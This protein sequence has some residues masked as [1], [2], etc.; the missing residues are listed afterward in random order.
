MKTLKQDHSGP[1]DNVAGDKYVTEI[2]ALA[3]EDL[4]APIE[5]VLV[6]VRQKDTAAAQ[7]Q[8]KVLRQIAQKNDESAALV[9]ALGIYTGLA[10]KQDK[11]TAWATLANTLSTSS[12]PLVK[13]VCLAALLKLAR[14]NERE[15]AAI[16]LYLQVE[17]HGSH[18]KEAW[19][20][21][22]ANEKELELYTKSLPSEAILTAAIAGAFRLEQADLALTLAKQLKTHYPSLNQRI[23]FAM[24]SGVVLN[25]E[26]EKQHFWLSKPEVKQQLNTLSDLLLPLL[27]EAGGDLRVQQLACSVVGVYQYPPQDLYDALSKQAHLLDGQH[28]QQIAWYKLQLGDT[29]HLSPEEQRLDAVHRNPQQQRKWCQQFLASAERNLKEANVFLDVALAEELAAW[30]AQEKL[31]GNAS[32]LEEAHFKLAAQIFY[33]YKLDERTRI[34][35]LDLEESVNKFVSKWAA[36]LNDINPRGLFEL[37]TRLCAIELPQSGLKLIAPLIPE[38]ELWPSLGV[39]VYL[40]CLLESE[41]LNA[42]NQVVGRVKNGEEHLELLNLKFHYAERANDIN[43]AMQLANKMAEL[44]P[45]QP[46][47]WSL[48]CQLKNLHCDLA[49]QKTLHQR[50]PSSVLQLPTFEAQRILFFI[51]LAGDLQRADE[52]WVDWMSKD[53]DKNAMDL[54]NFHF[55]LM[56][57]QA[58]GDYQ[59]ALTVG[60]CL[61]AVRYQQED[62]E[63]TKLIVDDAYPGSRITIKASSNLGS[64]LL[65]L[66]LGS[67]ANLGMSK[68]TLIERL[69]PI[70]ACY[71]LA[72]AIRQ[73]NNDGSD[74]F[75][76]FNVPTDPEKIL[77][78]MQEKLGLL[79]APNKEFMRNSQ[80]PLYMRGHAL[81][82]SNA[83][84][85]ALG[86]WTDKRFA[87][88]ALPNR[89]DKNPEQ[90]VLD[91]YGI[92]Y[93]AATGYIKDLLQAGIKIIL[94]PAT[95]EALAAYLAE[96]SD[97]N[98]LRI[99][100]GEAGNLYR[101]TSVDVRKQEYFLDGLRLILDNVLVVQPK[102]RDVEL[103]LL[104]L[105]QWLDLTVYDAMRLS[106]ANNIPWLCM[107][108]VI[109]Q[110]H[111][112]SGH[113]LANPQAILEQTVTTKPFSFE[114]RRHALQLYAEVNLPI[115]LSLLNL[116]NL[117]ASE[118]TLAG[119]ILFKTI[120]NHGRNIFAP[121]EHHP[122][123]LSILHCY[124]ANIFR[125]GHLVFKANYSPIQTYNSHVFNHGVEL[126]VSLRNEEKAEQRLAEAARY[127][128]SLCADNAPLLRSTFARFKRFA[129]GRFMDFG[130]VCEEVF[131]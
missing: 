70:V 12:N 66:Q 41:Q 34:Y 23:L 107:D 94:P 115:P 60:A 110:L 91:A 125:N 63:I 123:L 20:C 43:T 101:V 35:P 84:E 127:M 40:R 4:Q 124:L 55:G 72:I 52:C 21:Y 32:E 28:S 65:G 90:I 131:N 80:L 96:L 118:S 73:A 3:P 112:A 59:P 26:L 104:T 117:A 9:E 68:I 19:L 105:K 33:Q 100:L 47:P 57:R 48:L 10:D 8:L 29:S 88:P 42:F 111:Q 89:G 15:D 37:A 130:K 7:A 119:Y 86:S 116:Y 122:M 121:Q 129:K 114:L 79:P 74:A 78:Y 64:L 56:V 85:A 98:Y 38:H 54:T 50:I 77:P 6:S 25:V 81:N 109:A 102:V 93:L 103:S 51:A 44:A 113:P 17:T 106:A 92:I 16:E 46:Y 2:K 30:L 27:D 95:K 1:G 99:G 83:L 5:S 76:S 22:Y 108:E 18:T 53:P 58:Y 128:L 126:Y 45:E 62:E 49:E 61:A 31:L 82:S 69:P 120:Q 75:H 11:D 67:S 24:A 13:D 71:Q 36:Q 97:E 14:G 87:K 39:Q